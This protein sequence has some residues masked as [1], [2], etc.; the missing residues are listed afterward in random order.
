M[1]HHEN[2]LVAYF[3]TRPHSLDT[4]ETALW[5]SAKLGHFESQDMFFCQRH[6]S[7]FNGQFGMAPKSDL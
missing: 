4:L 1:I 6:P 5:L 2:M 7:D 3:Q